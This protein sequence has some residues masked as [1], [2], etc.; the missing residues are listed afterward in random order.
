MLLDLFPSLQTR[1]VSFRKGASGRLSR[2][3]WSTG[4][5]LECKSTALLRFG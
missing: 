2:A 3:W 5:T 1:P 4:T